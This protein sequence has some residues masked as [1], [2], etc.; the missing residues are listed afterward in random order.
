MRDRETRKGGETCYITKMLEK[1]S[2]F[3]FFGIQTLSPRK[4]TREIL[5]IRAA[6]GVCV[7]ASLKI[8]SKYSLIVF[9]L[10]PLFCRH[11]FLHPVPSKSKVSRQ[12]FVPPPP[13]A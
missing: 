10:F 3:F 2:L 5:E 8:S 13:L 11:H 1:I 12:T 7:F 6:F 4:G 9:F